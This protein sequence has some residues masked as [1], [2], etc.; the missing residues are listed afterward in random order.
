MTE[1]RVLLSLF[2]DNIIRKTNV[3]GPNEEIT[4]SAVVLGPNYMVTL[5]LG[6]KLYISVNDVRSK[7]LTNDSAVNIT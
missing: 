5:H 7:G 4:V 1:S 2:P 6:R 3:S